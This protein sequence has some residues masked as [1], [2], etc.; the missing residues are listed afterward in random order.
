MVDIS[1]GFI[2]IHLWFPLQEIILFLKIDDRIKDA[3]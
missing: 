2:Y 1:L 3:P